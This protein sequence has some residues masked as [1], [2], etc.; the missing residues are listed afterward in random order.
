MP[1]SKVFVKDAKNNP[2]KYPF[3]TSGAK[4]LN[5]NNSFVSGNN[6]FL[7]TGGNADIKYYVGEASYSTDT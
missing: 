2:G 4:T 3:F 1:K 6:I 7:N 5:F